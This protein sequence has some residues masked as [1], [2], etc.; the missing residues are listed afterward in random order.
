MWESVELKSNNAWLSLW[1]Q[2][3]DVWQMLE[4]EAHSRAPPAKVQLVR[5]ME[6]SG[7]QPLVG[8]PV[9]FQ[10]SSAST[11]EKKIFGEGQKDVWI[12][13]RHGWQ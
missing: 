5:A 11:T 6:V 12:L 9:V 2:L 4:L 8:L 13:G 10:E 3:E 7:L 1:T